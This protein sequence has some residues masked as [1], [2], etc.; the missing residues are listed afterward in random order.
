MNRL[1]L[2]LG[3]LLFNGVS[4]LQ[5]DV[6]ALP[7][8]VSFK[9]DI[10]KWNY[11]LFEKVLENS[12]FKKSGLMECAE[13]KEIK[14]VILCASTKKSTM[15]RAL[16]RASIFSE[17][18]LGTEK[19]N[20]TSTESPQYLKLVEQ[21]LGHDVPS[22]EL[23]SFWSQL[24]TACI[25][26]SFCPTSEEEEFFKEVVLPTNQKES[27]FV[28]ISYSLD[29]EWYVTLSHEMMHAQYFLDPQ[30]RKTVDQFWAESLNEKDR[31]GIRK[32][33]STLYNGNDE[34]VIRNEFQAYLLQNGAIQHN[35]KSYV[36]LYRDRLIKKLQEAGSPPLA[37]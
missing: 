36:S 23:I 1:F 37:L 4:L 27:Q 9:E 14:G 19:G 35:L 10:S 28:V 29:T 7:E 24:E 15:N 13:I 11:S 33:L 16:T 5:A 31:E 34:F 3:A 2:C 21:A 18:T 12:Q 25:Q 30:Y 8:P 17:G 32:I 20:L 26:Q 22:K 6:V